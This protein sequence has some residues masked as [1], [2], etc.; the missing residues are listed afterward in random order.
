MQLPHAI[1]FKNAY[2][3]LFIYNKYYMI[4]FS[5]QKVRQYLV[6]S[7]LYYQLGESIISDMQYDQICVEV[8]TYLRT[9]SNS[10]PL[11]YHDIITKSLAEDASGFSIRKY[12]E[13]IVSTAMHLLYQRNYR[14]SMT[15]DTF[16]SRFGYSLL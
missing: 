4:E 16:L 3:A 7:F 13:E 5:Q 2:Y 10:N 11:P 6:H 14:K 8:G 12:P 9:N 15:F 1:K